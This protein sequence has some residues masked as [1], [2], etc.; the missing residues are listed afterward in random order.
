[1]V[2]VFAC[3]S[4]NACRIVSGNALTCQVCGYTSKFPKDKQKCDNSKTKKCDQGIEYC[5]TGKYTDET[6]TVNVIRGCDE[7]FQK[8]KFCPN[9]E[10]TC[11]EESKL[12][13]LKACAGACCKTDNCNDFTPS[14]SSA[15]G[16][17]VA[18]LALILMVI[19]GFV[20]W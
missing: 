9:A 20:A 15:S 18:K 14:T 19:A 7:D 11:K 10:K 5:F 3:C 12:E 4:F 1:M 8:L 13:D 2:I 17:M 16:I 6:G